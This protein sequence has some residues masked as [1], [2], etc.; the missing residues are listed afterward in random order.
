MK[1]QLLQVNENPAAD[2]GRVG[3]GK[4]EEAQVEAQGKHRGEKN[5]KAATHHGVE[6]VFT[7]AEV[8]FFKFAASTQKCVGRESPEF[9][10][11]F[12]GRAQVVPSRLL[13]PIALKF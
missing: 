1:S 9:G 7:K 2:A 5:M 6:A 4:I 8:K 3:I 13:D 12:N 10:L 11:E